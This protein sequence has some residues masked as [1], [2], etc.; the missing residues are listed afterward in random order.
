MA[1]KFY[2]ELELGLVIQHD[3]G[4]TIT[5]ADNILFCSLT[6]NT[7]PLHINEDFAARTEFGRRIV[8]GLL[9]LGVVVG[10][11]V[12][13]LTQGTI[14][15]NLGYEQVQHP[16]PLFHGDT[17]YVETTITNRRESRSRPD[18]GIITM[19]HV[20][21]NQNGVTVIEV[22]RSALFRKRPQ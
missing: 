17:I 12:S 15:A 11:T 8:N 6:L 5:E 7:Q 4:R 19:K 22:T 21:R 10:I 13:D 14:I 3:L 16:H 18:C 2:E 9:T 20:G 1:G